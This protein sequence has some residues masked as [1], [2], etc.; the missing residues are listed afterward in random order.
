M[1]YVKHFV[2]LDLSFRTVGDQFRISIQVLLKNK[3]DQNSSD[4]Q[5]LNSLYVHLIASTIYMA[6]VK[7]SKLFNPDS[8]IAISRPIIVGTKSP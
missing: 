2:L 7:A 1:I 4:Q 3:S 8:S 5:L 6:L